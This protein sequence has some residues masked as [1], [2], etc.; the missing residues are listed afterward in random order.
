MKELTLEEMKKR[1]ERKLI[2]KGYLKSIKE[3]ADYLIGHNNS[4]EIFE[5]VIEI[6]SKIDKLYMNENEKYRDEYEFAKGQGR[7]ENTK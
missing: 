5:E 4:R 2:Q 3:R 1:E 6:F 7:I